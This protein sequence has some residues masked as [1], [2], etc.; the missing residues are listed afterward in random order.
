MA[1]LDRPEFCSY[2]DCDCLGSYD[3]RLCVGRMAERHAHLELYN[4]HRLCFDTDEF[5]INLADAYYLASL[6]VEVIKDGKDRHLYNPCHQLA[7]S[8]PARRLRD[9]LIGV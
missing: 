5:E 9:K 2:N 7:I 6:M 8:D 4:T 3:Q 1:E